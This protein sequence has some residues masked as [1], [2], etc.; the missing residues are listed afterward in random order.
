MSREPPADRTAAPVT[1]DLPPGF[2]W[3]RMDGLPPEIARRDAEAREWLLVGVEAG[4]PDDHP[5]DIVVISGPLA[6]T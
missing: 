5:A 4:I 1:D 3:I 2:Y 6:P